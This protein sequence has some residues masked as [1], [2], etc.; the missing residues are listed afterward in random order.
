LLNS[1]WA[2]INIDMDTAANTL[3]PIRHSQYPP[4][5]LKRTDLGLL[6]RGKSLQWFDIR[7]STGRSGLPTYQAYWAERH[8]IPE[9]RIDCISWIAEQ[10]G[11]AK[12]IGFQRWLT[13]HLCTAQLGNRRSGDDKDHSECPRCGYAVEDTEHVVLSL[14]PRCH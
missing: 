7:T 14:R 11:S 4:A 8:K 5:S 2:E 12:P 3:P 9:Q 6:Q 10:P 13:K 1:R